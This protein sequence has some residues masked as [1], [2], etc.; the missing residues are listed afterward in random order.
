MAHNANPQGTPIVASQGQ[1]PQSGQ[2]H[3]RSEHQADNKPVVQSQAYGPPGAS[4]GQIDIPPGS[5]ESMNSSL[6]FF[7]LILFFRI[8]S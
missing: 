4:Q 6:L 5:I 1:Y 2:Q 8:V 3:W 7:N